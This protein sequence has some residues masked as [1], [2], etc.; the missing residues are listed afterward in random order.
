MNSVS[1]F[2]GTCHIGR[3]LNSIFSIV[4]LLTFCIVPNF[5]GVVRANSTAETFNSFLTNPDMWENQRGTLDYLVEE[6]NK[7]SK[8]STE[9][10]KISFPYYRSFNFDIL[11]TPIEYV[12][13]RIKLDQFEVDQGAGIL[14]SDN[15][16]YEGDSLDF[17]NILFFV[18]PKPDGSFHLFTSL[19]PFINPTCNVASQLSG[20]VFAFDHEEWLKFTL[21]RIANHYD[22]SVNDEVIFSTIDTERIVD[23]VG[24]GSPIIASNIQT[25]PS[26][27][28][29]FVGINVLAPASTEFPHYSQLDELWASDEYDHASTWASEGNREM[30][31]WGCAV[32]SAAM[33]L[34]HYG[35][36]HPTTNAVTDPQILN[37]WLS[38]ESDGYVR[39]GLTNWLAITRY[40][41]LSE[42]AGYSSTSLEYERASYDATT[43]STP[44]IVKNDSSHFLVLSGEEGDDWLI[45]DPLETEMGKLAKT[46][47]LQ[48]TSTFVPSNTDLSYMMFVVEPGSTVELY[49][50]LG[51]RLTVE[52]MVE[53]LEG[54]KEVQIIYYRKPATGKYR[55]VIIN[56]G[57]TTDPLDIYTYNID[58]EVEQ[59]ADELVG[60]ERKEWEIDYGKETSEMT[61]ITGLDITPPPIPTLL[62][63]SD[64]A[65]VRPVGLILDWEEVGDISLPIK[66]WYKSSWQG[67]SYGPVTTGTNSQIN[68]S[69][70]A[71]RTYDWQV[72]A[73]DS[74]NNC[75][76]WSEPWTVIIDGT[77]PLRLEIY[78]PAE[79]SYQTSSPILNDWSEGVDVNWIANYRIEYQYDDGHTF[80][81]YPY[82]TSTL[83]QRNHI[84]ALWEQGGVKYR[85]QAWDKAGNEGEWSEW[86]H[87]YYDPEP[88]SEPGI[89]T[90]DDDW[91]N[92]LIQT[93]Q[94]TPAT[95]K[96]GPISG[97]YS[98][99][100]DEIV[101]SF[102]GDWY[103]LGEVLG[104]KTTLNEGEWTLHLMAED[105]A[106]NQSEGVSSSLL[107][108][109]TTAPSVPTDLQFRNPDL[110]CGSY[111]KQKM[112]TVDWRDSTDNYGLWRYHYQID[113]PLSTGQGRG[114]WNTYFGSS[115]YTGSLNEGSHIIK[116]RAQDLASNY[117]GW[118][119][120]CEITY[121]SIAPTLLSKTS[122]GAD[123][124]NTPQTSYFTYEDVNLR[125]DYADPSCEIV[126][127]GVSSVCSVAPNI[128]DK[129]GNCNT[130][131]VTSTNIK[132]DTTKPSVN[133]SE[134]GSRLSGNASDGLSEVDRVEI[135]LTKP[136]ESEIT[137]TAVG[138][139][140]WSYTIEPAPVG[141]YLAKIVS[142]D[143]AGNASEELIK[144]YDINE[145][146]PPSSPAVL[147]ATTVSSHK[148]SPSPTLV[149]T[150]SSPT[151]SVSPS[152][153]PSP[154]VSPD[155]EPEVLGESDDA[156]SKENYWWWLLL[157]PFSIVMVFLKKSGKR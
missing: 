122:F 127:E 45:N 61:T 106:G 135:R 43:V 71:D 27:Y 118:S 56:N 124:Y 100:Y 121:D 34:K 39:G 151:P 74:V 113:Y 150:L 69:G 153:T 134:W 84:P 148:P 5:L 90:V 88:P 108:V 99:V 115:Q 62:S 141:G 111:T 40:A 102:L 59:I 80:S 129:A 41:H 7:Y 60:G 114:L 155:P 19:C 63:P 70:S 76:E 14:L 6:N 120:S 44:T 143:E 136:G 123:W 78:S 152:P 16:P 29:D 46:S 15:L 25:W 139:T 26:Y 57:E 107:T 147:G 131:L 50:E 58:G 17:T 103:W 66:Y 67:G 24:I 128:C 140:S 119:T 51:N 73:C 13:F 32:T 22:V 4:F 38:G 11:D 23:A 64:G 3:I 132:L 20:G 28:V 130:D 47:S 109:D 116:L 138:T 77:A 18:W 83:S 117:S 37:D 137:V 72:M 1:S 101:R 55:L 30:E 91:T 104:T 12:D 156:D 94:W 149:S 110:A 33:I 79:E 96:V 98:R 112:I 8:F 21:E 53:Q 35:V 54:G 68:A 105:E 97:Y 126:V 42:L 125:D 93:W 146:D 9:G 145:S 2:W 87:Y 85:V 95:D 81:G 65:L 157:L 10:S 154:S 31:E 48:Y 92:S 36:N 49:D 144:V 82:R 89:P 133:L 142:Y 86:R 52:S 75:S